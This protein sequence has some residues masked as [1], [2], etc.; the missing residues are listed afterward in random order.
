[1]ELA[2]NACSTAALAYLGDSVLELCVRR[3]LV[4]QGLSSSATLNKRALDFVRASAQANAMKRL[5]PLLSEEEA[6]VFRR[7]RNMGHSSTPKS[8]TVAEYRAATGM[9]AL[10]GWLHLKGESER[11][12]ALFMAAYELEDK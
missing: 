5:L 10:F 4:G 6:A 11:I 12:E 7:G 3:W 1:M 9:E 2:W 8:A